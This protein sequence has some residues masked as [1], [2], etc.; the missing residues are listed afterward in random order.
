[1]GQREKFCLSSTPLQVHAFMCRFS[2]QTAVD[3]QLLRITMSLQEQDNFKIQRR[4]KGEK[5]IAFLFFEILV[6]KKKLSV[7]LY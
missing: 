2:A 3:M 5:K 7:S 1:M 4:F 6:L